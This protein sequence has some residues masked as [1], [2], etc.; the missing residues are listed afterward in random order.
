[1][2]KRI[3]QLEKR[4]EE[5]EARLAILEARPYIVGVPGMSGIEFPITQPI[6]TCGTSMLCL[7]HE[8]ALE[9]MRVVVPAE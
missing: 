4:I 1:M 7:L 2:T 8:A 3:G 5:L 6:C 9:V